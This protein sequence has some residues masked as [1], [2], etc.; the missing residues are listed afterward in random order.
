MDCKR[1]RTEIEEGAGVA[2]AG[3][4]AAGAA[5]GVAAHLAACAGCRAFSGELAALR[6]L[7]AG[8]PR[9][10]APNDFEFRLRARLAAEGSR[11]EGAGWRA[12]VP[13][14]AWVAVAGCLLLVA[15]LS[16]RPRQPTETGEG[17]RPP[18][19]ARA[20]GGEEA[21]RPVPATT[22]NARDAASPDASLAA[23]SD[24]PDAPGKTVAAV[25]EVGNAPGVVRRAVVRRER[26][27]ASA[28]RG[29]TAEIALGGEARFEEHTRSV[30]GGTVIPLP[31]SAEEQPL[32][33]T[34]KDMQGASRVVRVDPV[35][36]GSREPAAAG[37]RVVNASHKQGVW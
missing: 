28:P 13:R 29:A 21:A 32:Q 10:D 7:V 18:Q 30:I 27:Q 26:R 33:V 4:G 9:V 3:H 6:G 17:T 25:V 1:Y 11:G 16:L 8:L 34:F 2:P 20:A 31:L 23:S 37:A 5:G 24:A 35:A 19:V 22:D 36:F 12:L 14:G 15:S